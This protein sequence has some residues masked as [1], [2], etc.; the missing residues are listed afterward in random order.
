MDFVA[1]FL[2]YLTVVTYLKTAFSF[3][4]SYMADFLH[5]TTQSETCYLDF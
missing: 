2:N 3:L 5:D 1:N 4:R